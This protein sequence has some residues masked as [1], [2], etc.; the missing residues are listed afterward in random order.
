VVFCF[1]LFAFIDK[2]I[3]LDITLAQNITIPNDTN[4]NRAKEILIGLIKY[5]IHTYFDC[6]ERKR[7][8]IYSHDMQLP[9]LSLVY[10]LMHLNKSHNL[11]LSEQIEP[12]QCLKC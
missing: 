5:M 7:K 11:Q 10:L 2:E 1:L 6:I 8:H 9:S 3:V 4:Q 12:V